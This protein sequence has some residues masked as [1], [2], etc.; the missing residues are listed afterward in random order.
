LV[1]TSSNPIR[2]ELRWP[3]GSIDVFS[4]PNGNSVYPRK[5][6]LTEKRDPQG[7]A[8]TL[9]YD[10]NLRITQLTDALGQATMLSYEDP[11]DIYKITKVTDPFGRAAVL[12]Y[13]AGLLESITDPVGIQSQ[14][15]YGNNQFIKTLTTPYG[16]THFAYGESGTYRWLEATDP[17]GDKNVSNIATLHPEFRSANP[18]F[19][20]G[21]RRYLT[22]ISITATASTGTNTR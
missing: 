7:N 3:D 22:P 10:A 13:N 17:Y 16:A 12:T 15:T 20:K 8:I 11:N 6:F 19:L 5:V 4:Q 2:Y 9:S 21:C 18:L 1:R 14:L